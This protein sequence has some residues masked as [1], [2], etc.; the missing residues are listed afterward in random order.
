MHPDHRNSEPRGF[1]TPR[2]CSRCPAIILPLGNGL[3]AE[4]GA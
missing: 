1:L 2:E 3:M 4:H